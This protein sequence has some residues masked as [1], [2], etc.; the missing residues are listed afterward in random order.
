MSIGPRVLLTE[1]GGAATG[2][3]APT[4]RVRYSALIKLPA[5]GPPARSD[6]AVAGKALGARLAGGFA[7]V[8][9]YDQAQ[10]AVTRFLGQLANYLNLSGLVA[11][12]L[13][14]LGV[15]GAI[16][17][18]MAQK[19]DTVAVLKCLG[20]TSGQLLT[21][22]LAQALVLGLAGSAVG[23]LLGTLTQWVLASLL[24]DLLPVPVGLRLSWGA[25]AEGMLLG[26]LV[27]LWFALPPLW[28]VRSVPPAR[29]FRRAVEA[30]PGA[31]SWRR[32]AA[33]Q[34]PLASGLLLIG[35]L[36]LWEVNNPR[37]A[38]IF[39]A[40]LAGTALVL[41]LAAQ[42]LLAAL[43][44][45]PR[46][47]GFILRQGL[48]ALYRPGNQTA[49]V[50]VSLGLGMLLMLAVFLIQ[51]D[52][53]RQVRRSSAPEQ[54]NL[55]FLD[56][57]PDQRETFARTVAESGLPAPEL[58]PVVRGRIAALNGRPLELESLPENSPRRRILSFEYAFTYRGALVSGETVVE[59]RFAPDPAVAGA[60]VSVAD[61]WIRETG[62]KL[63]DTL[64]MDVMGVPVPATITSVREVD[65]A[66]RRANFSF[67]YLPGVL[68]AAP[69]IFVSGVR[70]ADAAARTELQRR[71]VGR[72]PNVTG[73]DV[74]NALQIVQRLLDRIALVIEFMAGFSVA[75]GIVI[76][77]GS[78]ATTKYQRIREA[79]LLKTLGATRAMVALVLGL[80]YLLLG[81]LSGLV[82]A[83]AAGA[84]SYGLVT[85]VFA[86]R[87]D[88]APASYLTAWGLAAALVTATGLASSTDVLMRKPLEVLREE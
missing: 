15:A 23:V 36:A 74:D 25:A 66:N 20:A 54:P 46:P 50:V 48:S 27:T 43:R 64:T 22:Y 88:F 16:R 86:G 59:G 35:L 30:A 56:I 41:A 38:G 19:L 2:L 29:V 7:T 34:W 68:E 17:V 83:A 82:G 14:G 69:H 47:K 60:Q 4:S 18:F 11:L 70:V 9:S 72:L 61:W 26:G 5:G 80:E 57:Q 65:W 44:R 76:L 85:W 42:A 77:L 31:V 12:L 55:F 81:A 78:I 87:W 67:V 10:P 45:L 6:P 51:Q 8:A 58:I 24:A 32:R 53:L 75:V 28:L 21:V 84:L 71:V 62:L 1:G 37:M 73:F 33:A 39:V 79:V 52:L 40:G 3:I 13:G 49:A 63:G